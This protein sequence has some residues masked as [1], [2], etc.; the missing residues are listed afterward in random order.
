MEAA[1]WTVPRLKGPVHLRFDGGKV[2]ITP[3]DHPR[4]LM[5]AKRAVDV[6]RQ[7]KLKDELLRQF[8]DHY[9]PFLNS[10]C[11]GH[12]SKIK[13]CYLGTPSSYGLTVFVIGTGRYDFGLGEEISS[14]ALQL[15]QEGWPSNIL[16][17]PDGDEDDLRTFFDPEDSLQVY[18]KI[19]AA[20]GKGRT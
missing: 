9:L 16:Q 1:A 2:L 13:A 18:A 11:E 6:L 12:R 4:F 17:I 7:E 15:E 10:W 8:N 5:A 3:E 14:F 20:S 19:E